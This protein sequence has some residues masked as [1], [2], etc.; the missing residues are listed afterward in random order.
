MSYAWDDLFGFFKILKTFAFVDNL[1]IVRNLDVK[2][3]I[4]DI[5]EKIQQLEK[6]KYYEETIQYSHEG[7]VLD[8]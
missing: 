3:Y 7:A 1:T 5:E 4:S 6:K 2:S 8:S